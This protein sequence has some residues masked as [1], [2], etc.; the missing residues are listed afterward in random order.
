[1]GA[2]E[3]VCVHELREQVVIYNVVVAYK[4]GQM[5]RSCW[6]GKPV[7]KGLDEKNSR[8]KHGTP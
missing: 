5:N 6:Y 4:E 3:E 1:M 2:V 8:W 7:N